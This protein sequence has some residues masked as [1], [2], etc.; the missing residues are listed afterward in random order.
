VGKRE[1]AVRAKGSAGLFYGVQSLLQ[2][3]PP[4]VFSTQVAQRVAW[5]IPCLKIQ[6]QPRF[7]W[8]GFMLDVSRHFFSKTEIERVLEMMAL[9]KLNVFHWHL[10]DDQGWRIEI[11]KYPKL[12]EV[13]AWRTGVGFKL[14]PKSTTAYGPDGRYGGYYT[15]EETREIVAYAQARHITIVPEIEMPGHSSAA[16][17]AYPQLSCFGGPYNTDMSSGIFKGIYCA[18]SDEPFAFL[19]DVL[20]EVMELFPGSFIHIGGDEV[21]KDNW[22][23]CPKCQDR[24]KAE[25]LKNERELQSY[26]IRRIER[27]INERGRRVIGWSEIAEGGLPE[28]AAIMDWI[29]GGVE[30]ARAGHDV[31]MSPT[32][33]CYLDAYQSTNRANEPKAMGGF[34]PLEQV[35]SFEPFPSDLEPEFRRHILGGQGNLWTEYIPNLKQAEYMA[36]PRLS[37]LAEVL[38]SPSG[39]RDYEDFT[40]RLQMQYRRFDTLGVS[41]RKGL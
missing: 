22:K 31:V 9:H 6:D 12:T 28:H 27:F 16:L 17:S 11:K 7:K 10:V 36:L 13:G 35:Y 20:A 29:G 30:A 19:Q 38:W 40:R 37:A 39:L 23:K 26:F 33:Y 1:V 8:R 18:G 14:D 32:K 5:T 25:G 15:Q 3:L 24:M 2:L 21:P 34:L 4:E 41:Y